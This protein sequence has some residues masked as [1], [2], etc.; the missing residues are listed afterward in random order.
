MGFFNQFED[1]DPLTGSVPSSPFSY[2][3]D[4][5][6]RARA[7]LKPFT[8]EQILWIA[9]D[10]DWAI[11]EYFRTVKK[12]E[13][14]RLKQELICL[15]KWK[16]EEWDEDEEDVYQKIVKFFHWEGDYENGA[17]VFNTDL[18]DELDIPMANSSS[19]VDALKECQY[20]L[21]QIDYGDKLPDIKP[22]EHF[23]VLSLGLLS[24]TLSWL[25]QI[26]G[27]SDKSFDS[28]EDYLTS[29][30]INRNPVKFSVSMAGEY[31]I[32]AMDAVCH[33]EHLREVEELKQIHFFELTKNQNEYQNELTRLQEAERRRKAEKVARLNELKNKKREDAK[34]KV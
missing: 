3:P 32:K 27:P 26:D 14:D 21:D 15:H 10:I 25:N 1:F 7:L 13:I 28:I 16:S 6:W 24:S 8:S 22:F 9:E 5:A 17:W 23:A 12:D 34:D 18:E 2:M 11:E 19:E 4:I 31:A 20:Y 30:G 29:F 33:A